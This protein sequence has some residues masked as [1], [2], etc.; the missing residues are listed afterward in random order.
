MGFERTT[1]LLLAALAVSPAAVFAAEPLVCNVNA[2][3]PAERDRHL[4]LGQ[5]LKS[6]VAKV[7]E[8]PDGY[9]M[10]LDFKKMGLDARGLPYCVVEVA[11]WVDLESRCCP[12]V[13]FGIELK[14]KDRLVTL[15]LTGGPEVKDFLKTELG[16]VRP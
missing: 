9:E 14:G 16:L 7:A 4:A 8:L 15:R 3:S 10:T 6:A 2:L 13:D 1:P 12:F 5:E 11:Q